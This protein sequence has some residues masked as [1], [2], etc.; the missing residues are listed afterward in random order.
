[1]AEQ[2]L[3]T[4]I[5]LAAAILLTLAAAAVIAWLLSD[6]DR[7][8]RWYAF[9]PVLFLGGA[10]YCAHQLFFMLVGTGRNRPGE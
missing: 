3:K 2:K 1:M 10:F 6:L 7:I 4:G 9:L 5:M 8:G